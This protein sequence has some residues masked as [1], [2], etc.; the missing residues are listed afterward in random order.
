MISPAAG[1]GLRVALLTP[2]TQSP[3]IRLASEVRGDN[4]WYDIRPL[5]A[6]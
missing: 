4:G 1:T 5:T 6:Q 3:V 2:R